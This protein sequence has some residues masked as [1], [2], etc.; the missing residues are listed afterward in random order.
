MVE[1]SEKQE[2]TLTNLIVENRGE[3]LK[4]IGE[5]DNL[6]NNYLKEPQ[7]TGDQV[8]EAK[9]ESKPVS[10]D[11]ITNLIDDLKD[12]NQMLGEELGRQIDEICK[13]LSRL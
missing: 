7:K 9:E 10:G 6:I 1:I 2:Q 5:L 11:R 12:T 8:D 13:R 4:R 3:V